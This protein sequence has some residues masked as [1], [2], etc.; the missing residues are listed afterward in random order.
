M[1]N[2]E[3]LA[4]AKEAIQ[5]VFS[6]KSVSRDTCRENLDELAA[7][8]SGYVDCLDADDVNDAFGPEED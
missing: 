4:N 8:I 6:D 1:T 3:L 5:K 7:D 2:Q